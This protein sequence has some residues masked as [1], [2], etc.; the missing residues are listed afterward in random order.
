MTFTSSE[1]KRRFLASDQATW[2]REQLQLMVEDSQYN[3][4][5]KPSYTY[6][7]TGNISFIEWHIMYLCEHLQITPQDYLSNLRLKTKIR[8]ARQ[9]F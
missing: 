6:P 7:D 1:A 8:V 9:G 4:P 3:T 2:A 5:S